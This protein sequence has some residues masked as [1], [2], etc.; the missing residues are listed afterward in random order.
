MKRLKKNENLIAD[1]KPEGGYHPKKQSEWGLVFFYVMFFVISTM[2]IYGIT[3]YIMRAERL[4]PAIDAMIE[5]YTSLE[6]RRWVQ[7]EVPGQID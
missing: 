7:P 3:N 1:Q 4:D 6:M 5:R 2:M